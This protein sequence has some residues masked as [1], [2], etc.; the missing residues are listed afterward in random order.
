MHVA[1]IAIDGRNGHHIV[2]LNDPLK[3][4]ALP[5]WIGLF[6]ATAITK[7]LDNYKPERPMTHDLLLNLIQQTGYK[8]KHVEINELAS[9]TYFA[10]IV[11]QVNDP[12]SKEESVKLIDSRPSDA[13]AL[14]IRAKAAIFVAPQVLA[15][16]A[17]AAD[18]ARDEEEAEEFKKFI[19][20][21][22]ASDFSLNKGED[23]SSEDKG[24]SETGKE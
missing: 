5:I 10:T 11:L 6:E 15:D 3:R 1:G 13:I 23:A 22:K 12:A 21:L 16:G 7:A 14:A 19:E 17:I 24:S 2:I 18:L 4:R 9:G 8:V 20:G